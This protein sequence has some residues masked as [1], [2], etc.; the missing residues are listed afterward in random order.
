MSQA[1]AEDS[2]RSG[3]GSTWR[4]MNVVLWVLQIAR[5]RDVPDGRVFET[6]GE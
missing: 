5:R 4:I 2:T 6:V 3:S 1:L